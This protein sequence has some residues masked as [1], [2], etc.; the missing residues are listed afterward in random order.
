VPGRK[1][2]VSRKDLYLSPIVLLCTAAGLLCVFY[3]RLAIWLGQ[4]NQLIAVGFVLAVM[5]ICLEG[6]VLRTALMHTA[7]RSGSTIQDVDALLRKDLFAS[8][9]SLFGRNHCTVRCGRKQ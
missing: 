5:S 8:I 7:I 1:S 6:Q 4:V 2:R 9:Q 3:S